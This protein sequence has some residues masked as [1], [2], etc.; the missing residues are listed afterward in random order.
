ME[1]EWLLIHK[2]NT[3][4]PPIFFCSHF[5]DGISFY[6]LVYFHQ[7]EWL[8]IHKLNTP[9]TLPKMQQKFI[10]VIL[11]KAFSF[12]AYFFHSVDIQGSDLVCKERGT[13]Y[14]TGYHNYFFFIF[15][16]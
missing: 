1:H 10:V 11:K 2:L 12:L 6:M 5:E 16:F 8:L 3:P 14:D 7:H 13:Y 9:A 4:P 15:I